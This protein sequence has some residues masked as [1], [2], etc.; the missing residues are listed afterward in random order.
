MLSFVHTLL[1]L[2]RI[3][4]DFFITYILISDSKNQNFEK[5]PRIF[6]V[7]NVFLYIIDIYLY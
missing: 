2:I 3:A 6:I 4:C 5:L 1:I 7:N